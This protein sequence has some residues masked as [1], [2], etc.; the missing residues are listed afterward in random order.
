MALA[1]YFKRNAVAASHVI[2]GFD[3]QQFAEKLSHCRVGVSFAGQAASSQEG[4][5]LLDLL[6]RIL[7]RL[8]P[9]IC[10]RAGGQAD[11]V[12]SDLRDLALSINPL[13]NVLDGDQASVGLCVGGDAVAAWRTNI[14]V[15][16]VGWRGLVSSSSPRPLGDSDNPFGAGVAA[17]LGAG[18]VFR[19]FFLPGEDALDADAQL[20]AAECVNPALSEAQVGSLDL[21]RAVLVGVGAVGNSALWAFGKL[22]CSGQLDIVDDELLE[23]SN[24]QRYV[25][26]AYR[27]IGNAKVQI[28]KATFSNEL[29]V[30]AHQVNWQEFV[31]SNGYQWERVLVAVDSARDRRA[32][33]VSLPRWIANAWTQVGDIGISVHRSFSGPGACVSCL[34]LPA[35]Q[36]E[37]EDAIIGNALR[38]PD[39]LIQIRELLYHNGV[40]P[41]DLLELIAQRLGVSAEKLLVYGDKTLRSLYVEGI[42]GGAVLPV[43]GAGA[44]RDMLVPLAHQSVLSGLLLAAAQIV[45][46]STPEA[47]DRS[48]TIT[49]IDLR[50]RLGDCAPQRALKDPRNI[51]VC[52]DPDYLR[53]HRA[54]WGLEDPIER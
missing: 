7:A 16:S 8:Y 39:R 30:S 32:V 4:R 27:D 6:V 3:E 48:T 20:S 5:N 53:V 28:A 19:A 44:H 10:L 17:A 26:A 33:Q 45:E 49:R 38:I 34:Y 1:E 15:G 47:H 29:S 50:R 37:S 51:C 13:I 54:K 22:R 18:N 11:R 25:L 24:L 43:N 36:V 23:T 35:G 31:R 40:V 21:G 14:H 41:V 46:S 42:C 52:Q 2:A 9:E 12:A